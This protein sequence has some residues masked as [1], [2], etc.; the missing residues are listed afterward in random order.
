MLLGNFAPDDPEGY[1]MHHKVIEAAEHVLDAHVIIDLTDLVN[2][3]QR[4]SRVVV[5]KST[6]EGFRLT[7][8]EALW[9]G[10]P[11]VGGNVGGI[12]L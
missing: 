5:Q 11:V 4:L 2:S 12:R 3:F 7:V 6:R 8:T 10:T 9:K 1:E